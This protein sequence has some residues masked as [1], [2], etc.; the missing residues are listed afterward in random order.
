MRNAVFLISPLL[1]GGCAGR[2]NWLAGA[3]AEAA[4]IEQLFW[5]LLI[6]AVV[7]WCTIIAAAVYANRRQ[8]DPKL[9]RQA[10]WFIIWGGA[11][12]PTFLVSGLLIW[13]MVIL[14]DITS[15]SGDITV[16]VDGE[17]WWWRVIYDGPDGDVVTANEIRLPVGQT[18]LFRLTADDV[19]H[20]FWVP[21]LGGKMDMIP[22]RE[23]TL[24]LTPQK[25]GSWG[26]L[27]AEFCGGAHAL[28]RFDAVVMEPEDFDA[29]LAA[30]AAPAQV[31]EGDPG[32]A[33]FLEEGCGACHSIR[34]TQAAGP[35][36][37]DLTHVAARE[38]LGAGIYAM[39]ADNMARWITET[40]EMK[41]GI[42]MPPYP[43]LDGA[44]LDRL[45][46]F[47]MSLDHAE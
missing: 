7:I 42:D 34:G 17:R 14:R 41:P 9:E 8:V 38:R 45:V 39:N 4:R 29:W 32:L 43:D 21:A 47:L 30:E 27:C 35:V 19:I 15:D 24:A 11:V 16:R 13:G 12:I 10:R 3:G 5:V 40:H 25:T 46:T 1:L 36:G 37:P 28:M 18:A 31:A 2:H 22:G 26:G 23:T 44:R 20:S 6:G 33:I